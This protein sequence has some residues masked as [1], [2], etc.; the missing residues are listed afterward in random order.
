MKLHRFT[1]SLIMLAWFITLYAQSPQKQSKADATLVVEGT[2][3]QVFRS[4]QQ[5]RMDVLVQVEV[6]KSEARKKQTT[7]VRNSIPGPGE[8]IYIHLFQ[9]PAEFSEVAGLEQYKVPA[10]KASIRC[11]VAPRETGGWEGVFP[12]WFEATSLNATVSA[13]TPAANSSKTFGMNSELISVGS[14]NRKGL[15]VTSVERGGTAQ[16]AGLEVGDIIVAANGNAITS[17][18]QLQTLA[19]EKNSVALHVIDISTGQIAEIE[20]SVG[21]V[22]TSTPAN[23]NPSNPSANPVPVSRG[24]SLGLAAEPVTVG[25]RTAMKITRIDAGSP[26]AKAGLEVNDVI[27]DANGFPVT[28]AE[29][30]ANAIRK[31]GPTLTLT[32][33]DSRT[34]KNTPVQVALGTTKENK[35][36]PGGPLEGMPA[37]GNKTGRFGVVSEFT[38]YDTE[39]A[40]KV[41]ELEPGSIAEGAGL[42]VGT[43][44]LEANGKAILH[45]NTLTEVVRSAAGGQLRLKIV[46]PRGNQPRMVNVNV[47]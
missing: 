10:E 17:I 32:V 35:P 41:T 5:N 16:K 28:G 46:D 21:T 43:I 39:A 8:S 14:G 22:A 31:S 45:P 47:P 12:D 30:L 27:V 20:I 29:Q 1:T 36:L 25:E 18:E 42:K 6:T 11:Y 40:V 33:R 2:V 7:T 44:I 38:L 9:L 19:K 3:K 15:K 24:P 34:G 26:A 23:T 37:P 4:S 13:D